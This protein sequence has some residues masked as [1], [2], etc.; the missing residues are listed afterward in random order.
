MG[1]HRERIKIALQPS[2]FESQAHLGVFDSKTK[3]EWR[4]SAIERCSLCIWTGVPVAWT[5]EAWSC[6]G[7][8]V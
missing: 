5:I 2:T 6:C 4:C 3:V 7:C 8:D 1:L